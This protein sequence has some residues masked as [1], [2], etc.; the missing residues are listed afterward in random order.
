MRARETPAGQDAA[1]AGEGAAAGHTA[2]DS[3]EEPS[4]LVQPGETATLVYDFAGRDG[5][6]ISWEPVDHMAQGFQTTVEIAP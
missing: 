3:A 4:V 6:V 1:S 5:A 2:A